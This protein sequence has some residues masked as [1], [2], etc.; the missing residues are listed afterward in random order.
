MAAELGVDLI[1]TFYTGENFA[2]IVAGTPV[3]ILALGAK[4]TKFE[5]DALRLAASAVRAGARGVV[6]GRNVIQAREPERFLDALKEV[7]KTQVDPEKVAVKFKL[8]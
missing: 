2:D 7:V 6:F 1:K 4:K 8:D 5:R 3:P